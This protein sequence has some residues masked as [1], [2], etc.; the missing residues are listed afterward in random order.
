[1]AR[2]QAA[3]VA[4]FEMGPHRCFRGL[5]KDSAVPVERLSEACFSEARP[6]DRAVLEHSFHCGIAY[7]HR[8]GEHHESV[9]GLDPG[10]ARTAY[11]TDCWNQSTPYQIKGKSRVRSL[12]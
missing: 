7:M 3:K 1:M 12:P 2:N 6:I 8:P 9:A 4:Q 11:W 10:G 5:L